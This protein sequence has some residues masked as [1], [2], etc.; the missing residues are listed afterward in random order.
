MIK[1]TDLEMTSIGK[2]VCYSELPREGAMMARGATGGSTRVSQEVGA[3]HCG[4]SLYCGFRRK[5]QARQDK[6]DL[7]V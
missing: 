7:F 2:I 4:K 6:Q 5:E 3:G 1:P